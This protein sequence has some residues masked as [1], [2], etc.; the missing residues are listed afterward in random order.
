MRHFT[1]ESSLVTKFLV[2]ETSFNHMPCLGTYIREH[3]EHFYEDAQISGNLGQDGH[4]WVRRT[5]AVSF[6]AR[7]VANFY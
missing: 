2:L 6:L 3:N 7:N 1:L 5:H 4:R